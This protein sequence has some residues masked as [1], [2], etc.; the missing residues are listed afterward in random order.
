M[1]HVIKK[2]DSLFIALLT[3]Q[4]ILSLS[5]YFAVRNNLVF[6]LMI[7]KSIIQSIVILQ[8]VSLIIIARFVF[9][10]MVGKSYHCNDSE[11]RLT[12]YSEAVVIRYSIM[13][14]SNLLNLAGYILTKENILILIVFINLVLYLVYRPSRKF[15]EEM[16]N[17]EN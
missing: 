9:N 15:F 13:F 3:I 10:K 16:L 17:K 5:G 12:I 2:C 11:I 7:Y 6:Q 8:N 14:V 1:E 4:I